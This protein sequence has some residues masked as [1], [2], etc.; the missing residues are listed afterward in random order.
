MELLAVA[1]QCFATRGYA[2]T[3]MRDI[4]ADADLLAGSIYHHFASKDEMLFEAYKI[5][6]EHVIAAHDV[7]IKD[8]ATPW[9][10]I[11]A[12]C[13]AHLEC[14]LADDPLARLLPL[15]LRPLPV[16]LRKR[17][18]TERDRYERR[19]VAV[20]KSLGIAKGSQ[21][22]LARMMLLGA[23]NWTPTWYRK[24]GE[25]PR[26]IARAY[27]KMLRGGLGPT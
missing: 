10:R 25:E 23:L 8:V 17:L 15:D 20:I 26:R 21:D 22:R 12:A 19:F 7:A 24:D 11:E 1:A 9:A 16:E 18:V 13:I 27:V 6:V 3:S 14:L 2:A 4:A 5:G